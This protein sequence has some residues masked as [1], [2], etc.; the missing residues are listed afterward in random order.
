MRVEKAVTTV[1]QL[2]E[3]IGFPL[4]ADYFFFLERSTGFE[5]KSG[6]ETILLWDIDQLIEPNQ[7]Y[8]IIEHFKNTLVIGRVGDNQFLA[9]K[10]INENNYK[11]IRS[12]FNDIDRHYSDEVGVS[13]MDFLKGLGDKG[14]NLGIDS[15]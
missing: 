2:E 12:G 6:N 7:K 4:P 14:L 5:G 11:V 1:A 10:M 3:V 13:F 15:R 8:G 9:I